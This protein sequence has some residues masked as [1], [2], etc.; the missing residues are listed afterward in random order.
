MMDEEWGRL[1]TLILHWLR[2][3]RYRARQFIASQKQEKWSQDRATKH[4]KAFSASD[5]TISYIYI[6]KFISIILQLHFAAGVPYGH[7]L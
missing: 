3:N 5:D 1:F 7:G 6:Y 2:K 4:S